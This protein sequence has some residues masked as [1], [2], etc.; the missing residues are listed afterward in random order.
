MRL[1]PDEVRTL[2]LDL[3]VDLA[4][5]MPRLRF[6]PIDQAKQLLV[7]AKATVKKRWRKV[8]L[9][10]H[11]DRTGGDP[12]KEERFK[13]FNVLVEE[14]LALE[15]S[16]PPPPPPVMARPFVVATSSATG[17]ATTTGWASGVTFVFT[18][19]GVRI[20]TT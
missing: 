15:V 18:G 5:L 3:G 8:A 10:L 2:M 4:Q 14:F 11:P 20:V 9:E 7:D 16:A 13:K 17:S 19:S 6:S 1:P 12:A